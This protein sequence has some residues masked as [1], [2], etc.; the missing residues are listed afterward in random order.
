M[1]EVREVTGFDWFRVNGRVL[2][3]E[4]DSQEDEPASSAKKGAQKLQVNI[5][6]YIPFRKYP[7]EVALSTLRKFEVSSYRNLERRLSSQ[8]LE[9]E[10]R[11]RRAARRAAERLQREEEMLLK[12]VWL[13]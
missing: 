12:Q 5:Y 6:H 1:D 10:E 8:E 3:D 11:L 2:L 7:L 13:R 9:A 4:Y